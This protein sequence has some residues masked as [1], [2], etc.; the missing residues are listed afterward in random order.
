[1]VI[2]PVGDSP[3]PPVV[4][5]PPLPVVIFELL[6]NITVKTGG[7]LTA[8]TLDKHG[9]NAHDAFF[10]IECICNAWFTIEIV[11]RYQREM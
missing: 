1:V 10:Y 4:I 8:W 11:V 5:A 6:R 9:T 3:F 7:N 2:S